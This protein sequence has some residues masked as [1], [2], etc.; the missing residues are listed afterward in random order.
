VK[1]GFELLTVSWT[2]AHAMGLALLRHSALNRPTAWEQDGARPVRSNVTDARLDDHLM[3][4]VPPGVEELPAQR[5]AA[6]APR[7]AAA[8]L[9]PTPPPAP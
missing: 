5:G 1:D 6:P 2:L 4:R 3:V 8:A 9:A 7:P